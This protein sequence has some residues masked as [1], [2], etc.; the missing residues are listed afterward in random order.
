MREALL[1]ITQRRCSCGPPLLLPPALA[2]LTIPVSTPTSTMFLP[3]DLLMWPLPLPLP[4][5]LQPLA[6][7]A[8]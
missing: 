2:R 8:E 1:L 7:S 4:L 3:L 5:L 6:T